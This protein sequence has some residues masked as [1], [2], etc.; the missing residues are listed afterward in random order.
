VAMGQVTIGQ[1]FGKFV[2]IAVVKH[3]ERG[4]AIWSVKC[5]CG[6]VEERRTDNLQRKGRLVACR[7]C[8]NKRT[9]GIMQKIKQ[10]NRLTAKFFA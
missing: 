3:D 7:P 4:R 2:T 5:D 1:R 6:N 8:N 9:T 10:R